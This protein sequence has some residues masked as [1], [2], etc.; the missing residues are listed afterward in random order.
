M[1]K[2]RVSNPVLTDGRTKL[3]PTGLSFTDKRKAV[4]LPKDI[5][6]LLGRNRLMLWVMFSMIKVI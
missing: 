2:V 1:S 4:H 5:M 6:Y 3:L